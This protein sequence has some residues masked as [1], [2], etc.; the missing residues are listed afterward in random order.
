MR[1]KIITPQKNIFDDT[2]EEAILPGEDGEF[3]VMDFHQ[4]CL[5]ALRPGR[6]KINRSS[7]KPEAKSFVIKGGVAKVEENALKIMAE[8]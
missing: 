4:P 5:Y 3:S 2:A 8:V 1:V 7:P 6:I